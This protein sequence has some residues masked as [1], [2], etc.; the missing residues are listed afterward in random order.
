TVPFSVAGQSTDERQRVS[1]NFRAISEG[2]LSTVG[3]RLVQGRPF[4]ENDGAD[5]PHVALVSAALAERFLSGHA[6]GQRLFVHDNNTGPRPLE[7]VGVV[8]N[9]R[10]A[11]LD[12][13]P[14]FDIYV[15]LR[16]V[17]PDGVEWLRNNQF[18]MVRTDG[19]PAAFRA[20]FLAHLRALDPDA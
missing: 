14:A 11:A 20:T 5:A 8:E 4:S 17:H 7:I 12:L 16:Q 9:V 2:Y 18:W 10:Q 15:P 1:A 3:T 6:I 13:P 19:D